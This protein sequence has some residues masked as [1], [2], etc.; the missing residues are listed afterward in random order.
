MPGTDSGS[1]NRRSLLAVGGSFAAFALNA[2]TMERALA[3]ANPA[4]PPQPAA[5][6]Q[7]ASPGKVTLDRVGG[8]VLM[9]GIDRPQASN[10]V[11]PPILIGLGKA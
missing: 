11:D 5:G 4:A 7:A 6:G 3:Q 2:A 10:R 1:V 9:I 8:G